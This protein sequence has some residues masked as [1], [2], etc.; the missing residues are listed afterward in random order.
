MT[1]NIYTQEEMAAVGPVRVT[2]GEAIIEVFRAFGR[3]DKTQVV[4][5]L[6]VGCVSSIVLT[7][8][9]IMAEDYVNGKA[10]ESVA[11]QKIFKQMDEN[12]KNKE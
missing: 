9:L 2:E 11:W 3:K 7:I 6:A 8:G 12:R 10:H 1:N 4:T 5:A